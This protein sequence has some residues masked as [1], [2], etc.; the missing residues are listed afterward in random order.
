MAVV[1]GAILLIIGLIV[2]YVCVLLPNTGPPPKLQVTLSPEKIA[3]GQYLANHVCVCMDCHS[4]RDYGKF[5]GPPVAG[6]P[7]GG[8][9]ESFTPEMGFPG[10]FYAKN[11]TPY[12]L[13]SWTDGEI[14]RAITTGQTKEGR[15][16]FPLMPYDAYGKMSEDDITSIIAYLRTLAPVQRDVPSSTATFPVNILLH[17]MPHKASPQPAPARNNVIAYGKY[18]LAAAGC[19]D[20]HTKYENGKFTGTPL[21]GGR[22]FALPQG[23]LQSS[24]LTPDQATGIGSWTES[25]FVGRFKLYADS[26][27]RNI[28]TSP[29]DFNTPMAWT[30]YSGMDTSDLKAIYAYLHSLA[31]VHN[32]VVKFVPAK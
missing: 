32:T 11:I 24:N 8:G 9:G 27:G 14:F 17:T 13:K 1:L 15:A 26:T 18:L 12:H 31:P 5:S 6:E 22:V 7:M 20:C 21:A 2:A 16:I 29:K 28:P 25:Q 3:R 23:I 10:T 19:K 30:M 4:H